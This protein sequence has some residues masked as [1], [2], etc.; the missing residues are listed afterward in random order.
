MSQSKQPETVYVRGSWLEQ[1]YDWSRTTLW[2]RAKN[3][4]IPQPRYLPGGQKRWLL[5]EILAWEAEHLGAPEPERA[6]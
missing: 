5:S 1:R 3:R 4:T 2:R 6:S